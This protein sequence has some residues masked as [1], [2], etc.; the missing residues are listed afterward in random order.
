[1]N[2]ILAGIWLHVDV[3]SIRGPGPKRYDPQSGKHVSDEIVESESWP[4]KEMAAGGFTVQQVIDHPKFKGY[5]SGGRRGDPPG[6]KMYP[7]TTP[8]EE[9]PPH[10]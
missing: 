3:G 6:F 4:A 8:R 5:F 7:P 2:P 9:L 1:L 10:D